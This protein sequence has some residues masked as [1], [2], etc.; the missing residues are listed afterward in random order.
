MTLYLIKT[1]ARNIINQKWYSVINIF[2]LSIGIASAI[3]IATFVYDEISYD[4]FNEDSEN[5]F[6]IETSAKFGSNDYLS[7]STPVVLSS[8]LKNSV[9]DI[10]SS[11]R[12]KKTND[13]VVNISD[14]LYIEKNIYSSDANIFDVFSIELLSGSNQLDEPNTIIITKS[15]ANKYFEKENPIGENLDISIDDKKYNLK[16][17]GIS[18]D[19]PVKSHFHY[20]FL[21]SLSTFNVINDTKWVNTN[22]VTYI[23]TT[24]RADIHTLASNLDNLTKNNI[25]E[26]YLTEN[27][28]KFYLKPL[29]KIH[30]YS[31]LKDEF[32]NNGNIYLLYIFIG[33]SIFILLISCFNYINLSLGQS[34]SRKKEIGIRNLLGANRTSIRAQLLYE[35]TILCLISLLV[36]LGIIMLVRPIYQNFLYQ[37]LNLNYFGSFYAIPS[38]I[39]SCAIIGILSG[40]IPSFY[41]SNFNFVL[42]QKSN[43]LSGKK[44]SIIL[45]SIVAFQFILSSFL[46]I[47]AITTNNQM[48]YIQRESQRNMS[49]E[50]ILVI[51][52]ANKLTNIESFKNELSILP[53]IKYISG[54]HTLPGIKFNQWSCKP[55]ESDNLNMSLRFCCCDYNFKN[56]LGLNLIEGRFFEKNSSTD[57]VS[58][59]INESAIRYF[60]WSDAIGKQ[61]NF[62]DKIYTVIGVVKDFHYES[63]Y[64]KIE[65]IAMVLPSKGKMSEKFISVKA[66]NGKPIYSSIEKIWD[67]MNMGI[68]FEYS[69]LENDYFTLYEKETKSFTLI[70][71]FTFLSIIIACLGLFGTIS[72]SIQKK[73][74]EAAVRKVYGAKSD[75]LFISLTKPYI[76]TTLI[77][78]T[79]GSILSYIILNKWFNQFEY[80]IDL[81]FWILISTIAM[82]LILT[83]ITIS[84]HIFKVIRSKPVETLK[85]E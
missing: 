56:T 24:N 21:V 39:I 15:I 48:K 40:S 60:G 47:G 10:V 2:G 66:T 42:L 18:E 43:L 57:N 85:Y 8:S 78:G 76:K 32:E 6:R 73:I 71:V 11:T 72:L 19:I 26:R 14:N 80:H 75:D 7:I 3:I 84:F 52:N 23:K 82:L 31:S 77:A 79:I 22:V 49:L 30:L 81:S 4:R 20:D 13:G 68:P 63:L 64:S 53:D 69:Y 41:L 12:L 27:N 9:P 36:S 16:I 65:P 54:S 51:K 35:S 59:V 17:T 50:N 61:V 45:N 5:I 37:D 46:L 25:D 62:K 33:L 67:K 83:L 44:N 28:W 1:A 38:I 58:M 55:V 70:S 74:K 34:L 29:L